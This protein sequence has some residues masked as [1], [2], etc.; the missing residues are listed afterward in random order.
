MSGQGS[1]SSCDTERPGWLS[2]KTRGC[3]FD[4]QL[5]SAAQ[6]GAE[7]AGCVSKSREALRRRVPTCGQQAALHQAVHHPQRVCDRHLVALYPER[8]R[9]ESESV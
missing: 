1:E 4:S 7:A 5:L 6:V 9:Q 2:Q 8:A 3:L